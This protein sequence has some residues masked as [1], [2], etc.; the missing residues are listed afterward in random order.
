MEILSAGKRAILQCLLR[1]RRVFLDEEHRY[2]LNTLY[3]NDYCLW[4]QT[5]CQSKWLDSLVEAMKHS[6]E[7]ELDDDRLGLKFEEK[8]FAWKI[9]LHETSD[10]D[11]CSSSEEENC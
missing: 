10:T 4:L 11:D 9:H 6:I 8:S 2:L 5:E 7:Y 3:L 1:M